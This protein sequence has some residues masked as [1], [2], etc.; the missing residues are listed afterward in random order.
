MKALVFDRNVTLGCDPEFFFTDEA[1]QTTGAEKVLPKNG[2]QYKTDDA[3]NNIRDV[4]G[5]HSS[6]LRAL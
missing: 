3:E 6:M 1:G 4:V 5:N 2:L